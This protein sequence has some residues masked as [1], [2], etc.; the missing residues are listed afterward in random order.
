MSGTPTFA[1]NVC[2]A[3]SFAAG[4]T[5]GDRRS[6]LHV[7]HASR[8]VRPNGQSDVEPGRPQ[9]ARGIYGMLEILEPGISLIEGSLVRCTAEDIEGGENSLNCCH[10]YRSTLRT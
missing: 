6:T 2:A 3:K 8:W 5:S 7:D 9:E 1:R 4:G 10:D